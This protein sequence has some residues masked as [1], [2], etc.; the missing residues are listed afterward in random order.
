MW[1]AQKL[2]GNGVGF[3]TI[4]NI[5]ALTDCSTVMEQLAE[6][7]AFLSSLNEENSFYGGVEN[8]RNHLLL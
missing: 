4:G 8:A 3:D 6:V 5:A 1:S 2:R 7:T